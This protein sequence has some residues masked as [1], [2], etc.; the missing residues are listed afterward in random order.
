MAGS[1]AALDDGST[2]VPWMAGWPKV[3]HFVL[4]LHEAS[5]VGVTAGDVVEASVAGIGAL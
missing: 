5:V 3:L 4:G 1:L 2:E